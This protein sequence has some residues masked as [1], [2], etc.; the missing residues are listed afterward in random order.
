MPSVNRYYSST[1]IDTTLK[2]AITDPDATSFEVNSTAGFP[3]SYPYTLALGYDLSNEELVTIIGA[4]GTI[5][6]VGLTVAGGPSVAGRGVD[7]TNNQTHVAAEAVKHVIS[8]R[9]MTEA[10]AHIAAEAG[11]HGI[12]GSF[13]GTT[14]AQALTNKTIT[15]GTVNATTL[16][17][18][19][20]QAVTTTGT[21]TLTNKTLTS[22]AINTPTIDAPTITGTITGAVITSANIVDGTITG[23][24]IASGTITS[25]NIAD[26]TIVN[27]DIN[28]SA[29]IA[30]TKIS[31]TAVT[32]AGTETL[33]NKTISDLNLN[34]LT[35]TSVPLVITNA[36]PAPQALTD[37]SVSGAVATYTLASAPT[38]SPGDRVKISVELTWVGTVGNVYN[39]FNF[40]NVMV[41]TV[42]GNTFTVS[43]NVAPP[44]GSGI[45]VSGSVQKI[46]PTNTI[47]IRNSVGTLLNAMDSQGQWTSDTYVN[48]GNI[49][50][51]A[52]TGATTI[53]T[54][55]GR[56]LNLML[57]NASSTVSQLG[58]AFYG[59]TQANWSQTTTLNFTSNGALISTGYNYGTVTKSNSS[60]A[61]TSSGVTNGSGILLLQSDTLVAFYGYVLY[62]RRYDI[63]AIGNSTTTRYTGTFNSDVAGINGIATNLVYLNSSG[64]TTGINGSA[65]LTAKGIRYG[66]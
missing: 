64:F 55:T 21:Q 62:N 46:S 54:G 9:D 58:F 34:A 35:S 26:G 13:V 30:T 5:L 27:A 36:Q 65:S 15:G 14:D 20:I 12:T 28:A 18:G 49:S 60:T 2:F 44:S 53:T 1:A 56:T 22:P 31:G 45:F 6:T 29:A 16:Q 24:D 8:A 25:T 63:T 10:Q 52:S 47:A 38:F 3:T 48:A 42:S 57:N 40:D 39:P 41:S 19:G 4:S 11:A 17:Q 7:G 59:T 33:T 50:A 51:S 61:V 37:A 66:A 23:S 32:L 43:Y